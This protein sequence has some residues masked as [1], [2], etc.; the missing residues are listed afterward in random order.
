MSDPTTP[1][2]RGPAPTKHLDLLWAAA[3]LFARQGVAQTTTREIAAAA[4]TTERTLFKHFG[5]KDGL[6]QAV[7]SQAV[8][9]HLAPTSLD[10][11]RQV[12]EAHG[13]DFV[14]WHQAL[15]AVRSEA[16]GASPE[17]ARLLIVELLRDDALRERFEAAW[18]PAVWVPL[19]GL[20]RRLQAEGRLRRDVAAETLVRA[21]LSVNIGHLVT[22]HILAP[23][24]DWPAAGEEAALAR[25]Y[26]GGAAGKDFSKKTSG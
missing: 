25:I 1:A 23:G 14:A 20:V 18:R 9:P 6:V 21:F 5:S 12:I 8:L 10:A 22:R 15:L 19:L 24:L 4:G 3:R 2:R 13:D 26:F 16:M 7:I 11:L 17:L